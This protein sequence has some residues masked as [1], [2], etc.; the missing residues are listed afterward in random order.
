M[1]AATLNELKKELNTLSPSHVTELCMRLAKY[2]KDNKELLTYLLFEADDE[3]SFIK[4]IKAEIDTGFE[5]MNKSNIYYSKKSIRKILRSINKY[6]RFSGSKQTAAE[7]LI[8]FCKSLIH[9]SIQIE[10]STAL[11]NIYE[12]QFKKINAALNTLH[13]DIQY[14][15][16][17]EIDE[18]ISEVQKI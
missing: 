3:N 10:K 7:V 14:D 9:S 17:K 4:E 2:K 12:A 6:I 13:E 18:L 16:R 15:F 11:K 8:Y 1:K 5:E